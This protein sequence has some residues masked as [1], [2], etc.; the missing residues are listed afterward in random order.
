MKGR[1]KYLHKK[2]DFY[3]LLVEK[4][5]RTHKIKVNERQQQHIFL[6]FNDEKNIFTGVFSSILL[7]PNDENVSLCC[8]FFIH[9]FFWGMKND[10][11]RE[12]IV[13]ICLIKEK[14]SSDCRDILWKVV[15]YYYCVH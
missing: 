10:K 1:K 11:N 4:N 15:L 8:V 13:V 2:Y 5:E 9:F 3:T 7:G 14:I 12:K 6:I